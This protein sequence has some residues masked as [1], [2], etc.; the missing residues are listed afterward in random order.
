MMKEIQDVVIVSACRTP[1][2]KFLGSLKDV[3]AIDL[4]I[5]VAKEAIKRAG[6]QPDI[7]DEIVMGE[8]YPHMQ[9]SLP[10]R[11]VGMAA[12]LPVRSNACNV[13]QNCASGMRALDIALN[14]IQLGKTDV[15]L[16]VGV[17]SMTNAPY[18]IPKARM[19]YRMGPGSI[20]DA[21]LHDGLIDRLVP[22]HMGVTAENIAEKYGITREECDQLAL[23]SHQRATRATQDGTFQREIVP[24]ELKSKKGVKIYDKDEHMIPDANLEAM[25]KLPSAFRKGGVVTAANASGLND[26]AAAV[27]IMSKAKALELGVKPLMK[28]INICGEGVAPEVMGLGPAVAIPKCLKEA[29]MKYEDVE[30]W[31]INEAFAPQFIGVG[32]MLKEEFGIEMDL[33]K[34]NANGSGIGLGHPVGCTALRIVVSLYYELEKQGKTVGGASLCVG[35]GPAYC[36]LWTRDI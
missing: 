5:I 19:G 28:L 29:G 27:I 1:I 33:S 22:G 11:Q 30:Y 9:G 35:G 2:A 31:E 7:I 26:A 18:M 3:Q 12:G 4:G 14:H 36:S 25:A 17:E 32:R 10:A 21:M 8:V 6:I 24:V 23:T 16:V 15:A 20:E 34:V 13:N